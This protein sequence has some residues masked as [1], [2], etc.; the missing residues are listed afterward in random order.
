MKKIIPFYA[1]LLFFYSLV[2][3]VFILAGSHGRLVLANI[4][5]LQDL[6]VAGTFVV[7]A[8]VSLITRNGMIN[9]WIGF[10]MII[11]NIITI[12]LLCYQMNLLYPE[13]FTVVSALILSLH[14]LGLIFGVV[15]TYRFIVLNFYR[16]HL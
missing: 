6:A 8:T 12:V 15:I 13:R 5:T 16:N 2:M 3:L 7:T 1:A 10:I 11:L 4:E 14:L 9:K